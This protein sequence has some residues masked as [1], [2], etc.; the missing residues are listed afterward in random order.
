MWALC[1]LSHVQ[2]FLTPPA[3]PVH[4]ILQARI[5]EWVAISFSMPGVCLILFFISDSS[6]CLT[7]PRH[8]WSLAIMVIPAL[9]FCISKDSFIYR[10]SVCMC[11]FK[12]C[13]R[14]HVC[15][16]WK[17]SEY[18]KILLLRKQENFVMGPVTSQSQSDAG[19]ILIY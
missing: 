19:M 6:I 8:G 10:A 14:T 2:L 11:M 4:G 13:V 16:F 3:S 15:V 5:L 12:V 9:S 1:V 7:T 18:N 17:G